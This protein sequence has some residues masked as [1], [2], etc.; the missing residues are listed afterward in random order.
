MGGADKVERQHFF[1]KLTVR[2]RIAAMADEGSFHEVGHISG[3]GEYGPDGELVEFT[4]GNFLF[5]HAEVDG[6][7]VVISGDDFTVRGGSSELANKKK[8]QAA[9]QMA[10]ELEIPIIRL[11]DGMGGGGSVKELETIGRTYVPDL[12]FWPY[13]VESMSLV[14]QVSLALGSVAGIGAARVVTSH[15][16]VMVE[17]ISLMMIAGPA[18]IDHAGEEI[19]KEDLGGAHVH[20]TNGAV[21]DLVASEAEAF[22]SARRF[23]SYLPSS[24]HQLPPRGPRHDD[25]QRREEFLIDIVPR[26][27]R[28][29]YKMREIIDAVVDLGSFFEIGRRWGKSVITGLARLD[30][31]PVALISEDPYIYGGGWTADGSEKALRLID[32]ANT[33]HLPILHLCDIPGFYI[34]SQ[35]ERDATIRKGSRALAALMQSE[36]PYASVIIRKAFGVAGGTVSVPQRAPYRFAWPSAD[37]GSLPIEGGIE[38]AYKAELADAEDPEAL[39]E[40]ITERLNAVRSPF[41]TAETFD[42]EE[43]IDPRDTRPLL[44]RWANLVAPVRK[45]GRFRHGYRP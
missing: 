20:T 26:N 34:G 7:P 6:R 27:R 1:G 3:L 30:G 39:K 36:V 33:F 5:G 28:R 42:I 12:W 45:T 40:E 24:A 43:M 18:L 13:V 41:R 4:P 19:T 44:C 11:I 38:V 37:W 8:S 29:P 35:A 10:L 25:P 21:D 16:S 22:D 17:D 31:W 2:E 15:Y 14:P 9:E 32:L 23:L